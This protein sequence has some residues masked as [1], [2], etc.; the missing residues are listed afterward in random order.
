MPERWRRGPRAGTCCWR[1]TGTYSHWVKA[2]SLQMWEAF[3]LDCNQGI[4]INLVILERNNSC[5]SRILSSRKSWKICMS[6][7]MRGGYDERNYKK[8]L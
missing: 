5:A 8:C 1:T 2:T 4:I 7:R 3:L 6:L